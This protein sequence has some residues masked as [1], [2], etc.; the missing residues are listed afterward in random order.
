MKG[1]KKRNFYLTYYSLFIILIHIFP[2]PLVNFPG[3]LTL[4]SLFVKDIR[5][6]HFPRV[7]VLLDS[8]PVFCRDLR[9]PFLFR[10]NQKSLKRRRRDIS[11]RV[12]GDQK[13]YFKPDHD[14]VHN[15]GVF[16]P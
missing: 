2:L 8:Q 11:S 12:Y 13:R 10:Q 14:V 6:L 3:A 16:V 4:P 1:F 9:T 15:Q 7:W 5:D